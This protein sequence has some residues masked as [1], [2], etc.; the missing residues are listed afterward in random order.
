MDTSAVSR[1]KAPQQN[2]LKCTDYFGAVPKQLNPYGMSRIGLGDG[3]GSR[4]ELD[5]TSNYD[6]I[7]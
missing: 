1:H 6:K 7:K 3:H 4:K 5:M 2:N